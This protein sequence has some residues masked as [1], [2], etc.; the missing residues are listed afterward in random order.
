MISALNGVTLII[1]NLFTNLLSPLPLQVV[2]LSGGLHLEA[3]GAGR[4]GYERGSYHPQFYTLDPLEYFYKFT[5][6]LQTKPIGPQSK[7]AS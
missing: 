4:V 3:Q 5:Y 2:S 6:G 1:T 7:R